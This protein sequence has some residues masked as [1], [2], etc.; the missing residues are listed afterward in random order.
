MQDHA[1]LLAS[2]AH[3]AMIGR[4]LEPDLS[5]AAEKQLATINA[6]A[7]ENSVRDLRKL[8]WCSIDNDD[9]RDLDQLT[10]AQ[11]L[12]G[13]KVRV[14]VAVADVDALVK[15]RTPI[16]DHAS[17]NTT[18]VYTAAKIFP[19]LPEKLSTNLT[20]LNEGED[21]VAFVVDITME[22]DGSVKQGDVYRARVHN[23]AQLTYN[24]VG[25]W[26]QGHSE[27]PPKVS[28]IAG[29]AENLKLQDRTADKMRALQDL[30]LRRKKADPDRFPDL[31]LAIVKAMG[32]GEYVVERPGEKPIGHFGLAVRDYTHS[33]APNRRFPD[34][35]THRQ[36]KAALS[37]GKPPYAEDELNQLARHC[38]DAED[39]ANKV[40]RQVRKSAAAILLAS[41]IGERFDAIVTGASEKGTWVRIFNP[42]VEGKLVHG[43]QGCDIGDRLRVKLIS[44]DIPAGHIDF[45]RTHR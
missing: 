6:P 25:M 10:L 20:S 26:L 32:A 43:A 9:S 23:R 38:T 5:K 2:I 27:P 28:G 45:A 12:G 39:A 11:D 33:T 34:L 3:Q 8:L 42:P 31:S 37:A 18:S 30:L 41:R 21:R 24:G 16:D 4:G 7:N 15:R 22:P 36:I 13:G 1:A 17:K 35:I 14:L 44:V 40:E 29:L 19:M